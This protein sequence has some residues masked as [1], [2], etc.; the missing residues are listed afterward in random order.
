MQFAGLLSLALQLLGGGRPLRF[1]VP[2]LLAAALQVLGRGGQ[3]RF[4]LPGLLAAQLQVIGC[5]HQLGFQV[6]GALVFF[7]QVLGGDHQLGFQILG[8]QALF[9]QVIG[10]GCQLRFQIGDLPAFL[11][12]LI[13]QGHQFGFQVLDPGRHEFHPAR[14]R[15]SGGGGG[16]RQPLGGLVRKGQRG[17]LE[18]GLGGLGQ[19][20]FRFQ[21][22]LF[23][24][25]QG[26]QLR[27]G[28]HGN[29]EVP[30][31]L[32]LH[33]HLQVPVG[34]DVQ[35]QLQVQINFRFR[36]GQDGFRL[37]R[38]FGYGQRRWN[39]GRL[40]GRRGRHGVHFQLIAEAFQPVVTQVRPAEIPEGV[41]Q[42]GQLHGHEGGEGGNQGIGMDGLVQVE[43]GP[44]LEALMAGILFRRGLAT[45]EGHLEIGHGSG[46]PDR[47]AK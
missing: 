19:G 5:H 33:R 31:R 30:F 27:Q 22:G 29:L 36:L 17:Q 23:K 6:L 8:P 41:V 7:L 4:Q 10:G 37:R 16:Q 18:A 43:I 11:L 3:S 38:S 25:S 1:Q 2:G 9:L 32:R 34:L 14:V 42:V 20:F 35:M 44:A 13:G 21:A 47:G 39:H 15:G 24:F 46:S 28:L 26:L 45:D 40:R 12:Q